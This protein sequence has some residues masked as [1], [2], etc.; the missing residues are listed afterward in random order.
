MMRDPRSRSRAGF[1]LSLLLV[2]AVATTAAG[3]ALQQLVEETDPQ[4]MWALIVGVSN[5]THAEPLAYAATDAQA[6]ADFLKSPRGGG[7]PDDH[8]SVLLEEKATRTGIEYE[9]EQFWDKVQEGDTVYVYIAGHGFVHRRRIG[10]F[11]PIDGD[12]R[13]PNSTSINLLAL[14]QGVFFGFEVAQNLVMI[15]DMCHSGVLADQQNAINQ[16]LLN[17][18]GEAMEGKTF[19]NLVASGHD[20][21]SWEDSNL[22]HGV[23]TYTLLEA[24]NGRGVELPDARVKAE[25]VVEYV[26]MEVPARTANQ[27]NP[28]TNET[29][30]PSMPL[31][32]LDREG[33][34]PVPPGSGTVLVLL[35]GQQSE[36]LR[37]QWVDP[38]NEAIAVRPIPREAGE[39]AIGPLQPGDLELTLFDAENKP[40]KVTLTLA[41]GDNRLD[42]Q[43][44]QVGELRL[45]PRSP[46]RQVASLAL[47]AG[48]AA[49]LQNPVPPPPVAAEP[50]LVL[51]LEPGTE[52]YVDGSL[53]ATVSDAS[54]P[55]QLR[56]L[57]REPV[58]L[59][60]VYSPSHEGRF[61][62]RLRPGPQWFDPQSRQLRPVLQ[63]QPPP[64]FTAVPPDL[65]AGLV[66]QYRDFQQALWE[67]RLI[68]PAGDSAWE[69]YSQLE[70]QVAEPRR[71]A[72]RRDLVVAMGDQA[73]RIVLEYL[74]G[75]DTKW[76]AEIFERG[77]ELTARLRRLFQDTDEYRSQDLFFQGR[78]LIERRRYPEARDLLEQS[79]RIQP[80][81]SHALNAVGLALWQEDRLQ[82]AL[83]PL[84]RAIELTPFWNYPRITRALV[85]MQLRR[86][87]EAEDGFREAL[88]ND[89]EDS[90]AHHGLGQ[91]FFVTG[92]W[93]EAEPQLSSAMRFDP[94][95]AYALHTLAQLEA[96][97]QRYGEAEQNLRLAIRLEPAE[98]SFE[99]TLAGLL[100]QLGRLA[101]AGSLLADLAG[102]YPEDVRV[103]EAYGR[104]L[105]A[106]NRESEAG[107]VFDR[108]LRLEP[109][110]ANLRVGYG[111]F[112]LERDR[113][114][115]AVEQFQRA[116]ESD[117]G[118]AFAHSR[119]AEAYFA[120]EKIEK[121]EQSARRAVESDPRYSPPYRL[122]GQIAF[123][124][125]RHDEALELFR[126]ARDLATE[127]HQRQQLQE[128]IDQIEGAIVAEQLAEVD[129][130]E[131]RGRRSR[132]WEL[133][134]QTLQRAVESRSLRNRIL[135]FQAR[136]PAEAD[137]ALLPESVLRRVLEGEFWKDQQRAEALWAGGEQGG[138]LEVF[139]QAL[140]G[141]D[142]SRME[143]LGST[144]FNF[145]N[146]QW[147]VH[148]LVHRWSRR[149]LEQRRYR[150]ALEWMQA[151]ERLWIYV[152]V[153]SYSP[154]T[155][156]SLMRPADAADPRRFEDFEVA[157]HPDR[158]A[159]EVLAATWA[160]LGDVEKVR[161]YLEALEYR[162]PDLAARLGAAR[163]LEAARQWG[164]AEALLREALKA[165][166]G[167]AAEKEAA[168]ALLRAIESK[169][170]Q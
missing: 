23:F 105:G 143:A 112:L 16:L 10:Y 114:S 53:Y 78:A 54:R 5:Y 33:P 121:A 164:P 26:R 73:Q 42:L 102:R 79:V 152:P 120:D 47:A 48:V 50:S 99:L 2:S 56:G 83:A 21:P 147:G 137:P 101:E 27:Q 29:Y 135:E 28:E 165:G 97:L 49:A 82:E 59:R 149:A 52:V 144:A 90:T 24:L 100:R 66:Q 67:Q 138:A 43:K 19:L 104:Y 150:A 81:A 14:Q 51:R 65:D 169:S 71:E 133:L 126:R 69:H 131:Q 156:D 64:A 161:D 30:D 18:F 89:P 41:E 36:Y 130:L 9:M 12:P 110:D 13:S 159:H 35:N 85:L 129:R 124:R 151:A 134:G 148:A 158:R 155:V 118:N 128:A 22:G 123:A 168:Q 7:I 11:L 139:A 63:L 37:A 125:R 146:E 95:N 88:G 132:A 94:G 60:L 76:N 141:L 92:R 20:E 61:R 122:L 140:A 106:A 162:G 57:G 113:R 6:F 153:P 15:T 84:E 44:A 136:H 98:P 45:E 38:R 119:L 166:A 4:K 127:A 108:A 34:A 80:E 111:I 31:S 163:G 3:L 62:L 17:T 103:L 93:R 68:E 167:S 70:D 86:Y 40:R 115:Q 75:G 109:E 87:A 160:G 142:G 116:L 96:R 58:V 77:S 55:L 32:Y 74:R 72:L 25:Q 8:V 154:L 39:V 91:L 1:V 117:P 46:A 170:K 157:H 145:E 107:A